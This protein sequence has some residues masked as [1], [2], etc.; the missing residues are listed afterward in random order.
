[1]SFDQQCYR[2]VVFVRCIYIYL[3]SILNYALVTFKSFLNEKNCVRLSRPV[4]VLLFQEIIILLPLFVVVVVVV[5]VSSS[6]ERGILFFLFFFHYSL[7]IFHLLLPSKEKDENIAPHSHSVNKYF[8][9]FI[10]SFLGVLYAGV[11]VLVCTCV[12]IRA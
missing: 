3:F 5:V 11:C 9:F 8:F 12:G 10:H 1:M 2:F 6:I 7:S 4:R